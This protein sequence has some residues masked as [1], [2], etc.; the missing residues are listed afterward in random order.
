LLLMIDG[1]A[2][3]KQALLEWLQQVGL[4]AFGELFER[5]AEQ[6]AGLKGKSF[7]GAFALSLGLSGGRTAIRWAADCG[8]PARGTQP[9]GRRG[10]SCPWSSTFGA[11]IRC[12]RECSIR[13]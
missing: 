11:S 2:L 9:H 7:E 3:S 10:E 8:Q 1:M 12:P 4:S 5:D 13:S 6:L